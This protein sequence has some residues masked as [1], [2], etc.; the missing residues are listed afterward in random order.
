MQPRLDLNSEI[1]L[2]LSPLLPE[3]QTCVTMD[4][5]SILL[6]VVRIFKKSNN[7]SQPQSSPS[8]RECLAALG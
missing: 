3:L 4:M 7:R 1:Y 6:F 2:P 5:V 8:S